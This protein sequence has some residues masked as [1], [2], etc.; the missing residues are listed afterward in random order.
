MALERRNSGSFILILGGI[1]L[2][3]LI[4]NCAG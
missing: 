4:R 1:W 3:Y 2:V